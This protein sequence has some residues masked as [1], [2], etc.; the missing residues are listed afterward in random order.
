M[1]ARVKCIEYHER[2]N[3]EKLGLI[4]NVFFEV[5]FMIDI[6]SQVFDGV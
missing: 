1:E 2:L 3:C 5:E 6:I 4:V